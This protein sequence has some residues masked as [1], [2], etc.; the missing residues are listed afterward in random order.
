LPNP[1]AD[2][3]NPYVPTNMPAISDLF[4]IFHGDG[5]DLHGDNGKDHEGKPRI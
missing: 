1:K 3:D 2:R 5:D 4:D